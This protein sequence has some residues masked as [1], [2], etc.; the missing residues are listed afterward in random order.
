LLLGSPV[1]LEV[2]NVMEPSAALLLVGAVSRSL[3]R[4][5]VSIFVPCLLI[6]GKDEVSMSRVAK[7]PVMAEAMATLRK[8]MG[9][10]QRSPVLDVAHCLQLLWNMMSV[11]G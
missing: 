7:K 3:S 5:A 10:A 1:W 6:L 9:K 11:E 8:L 2:L 4:A